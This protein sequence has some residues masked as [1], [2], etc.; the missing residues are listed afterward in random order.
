MS[1]LL[2]RTIMVE[3]LPTVSVIKMTWNHL[4]D[5]RDV[6]IAFRT[7]THMLGM[8]TEPAYI[9]ADIR[10][11]PVFPLRTTLHSALFG[12]YRDNRIEA[13]LAVGSSPLARSI[14][15]TLR[16]VTGRGNVYWFDTET[17]ALAHVGKQQNLLKVG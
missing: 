2:Q 11:N 1:I 10:S 3:Y 13:W 5:E 9:I 7:I 17:E 8:M 12:P 15:R 4:V 6:P 16:S 14:E